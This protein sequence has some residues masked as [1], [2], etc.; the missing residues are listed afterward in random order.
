MDGFST[1]AADLPFSFPDHDVAMAARVG[2]DELGQLVY[3]HDL[4]FGVQH[5]CNFLAQLSGV[6]A[7]PILLQSSSNRFQANGGVTGVAVSRSAAGQSIGV[8]QGSSTLVF[9]PVIEFLQEE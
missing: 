7:R 2:L 1:G 5:M 6:G 9:Q 8:G 4:P 3:F